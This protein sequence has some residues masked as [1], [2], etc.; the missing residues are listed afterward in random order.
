MALKQYFEEVRVFDGVAERTGGQFERKDVRRS[1]GCCS[2][3][4]ELLRKARAAGEGFFY[5][6]LN[7]WPADTEQIALQKKWVVV[8]SLPQD[9]PR[10]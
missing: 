8:S 4:T 6:P 9:G 5:L 10:L 3:L 7:S 1:G 2:S